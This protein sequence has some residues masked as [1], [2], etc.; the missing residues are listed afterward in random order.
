MISSNS[1]SRSRPCQRYFY[2]TMDILFVLFAVI[3]IIGE[4]LRANI[5]VMRFAKPIPI[6]IL[7]IQLI[8][9]R[10]IYSQVKIFIIALIFGSIGDILM[11]LQ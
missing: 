11:E 4:P 6:W 5:T 8:T 10:D 2:I 3:Y 7:I 9:I 1:R